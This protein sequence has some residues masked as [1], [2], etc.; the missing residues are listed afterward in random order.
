MCHDFQTLPDRLL[1][2]TCPL[3]F[4][5][6]RSLSKILYN[7]DIG[8]KRWDLLIAPLH[9]TAMTEEGATQQAEMA[10]EIAD[11]IMSPAERRERAELRNRESEKLLRSIGIE[12]IK[13]G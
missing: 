5:V 12:V 10:Q 1:A 3:I 4:N 7:K 13:R 9:R 6:W 8:D 2:Q 11:S